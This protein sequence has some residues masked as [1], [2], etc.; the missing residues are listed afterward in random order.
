MKRIVFVLGIICLSNIVVFAQKDKAPDWEDPSVIA[1]NKEASHSTLLPFADIE[2]AMNTDIKSSP[3][4][5][6]LNG[7]WKFN[8]VRMPADRPID[9]YLPDYSDENWDYIPVPAN[10]EM[11][12]YGIPIY[13]NQPYEFPGEPNPPFVPHDYNPVGSYRT[14]FTI[15]E[16]WDGREIF[17]HFGAVKSAFYIWVNGEKVG[18]SQGAKLPAEFN[19]TPYLKEGEN[20][21]ALEV[22]RWSDGTYLECQDFWR[23]SG[24]ERD[25]F[26]WSAPDIHIRD[27]WAK[28]SLDDTYAY[29]TLSIEMDIAKYDEGK[30]AKNQIASYSVYNEAGEEVISDEMMFG[31]EKDA[32]RDS[33]YFLK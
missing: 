33:L 3:Y 12:G 19:I 7:K 17:I 6:S 20:L 2:Q 13:V 24:I 21:L 18:Y 27:Y 16:N 23:V 10:W 4:Y 30:K 25:V 31:L 8:W 22:Y 29:G 26:L 9:F 5:K 14:W 15:P 11:Q 28:A 1:I 32:L